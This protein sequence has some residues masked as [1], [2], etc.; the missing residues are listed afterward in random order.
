M[1][2][3]ERKRDIAVFANMLKELM[4]KEEGD[5]LTTLDRD[6][7]HFIYGRLS[8]MVKHN[9]GK[10]V[11]SLADISAV[12]GAGLADITK[13]FVKDRNL[14]PSKINE[15][16]NRAEENLVNGFRARRPVLESSQIEE[17]HP[18][19]LDLAETETQ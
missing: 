12:V 3:K 16:F 6:I 19:D 18:R 11:A 13:E 7:Q 4:Q 15:L 5:L 1:D 9:D 10:P 17:V 2:K 14:E 8:L